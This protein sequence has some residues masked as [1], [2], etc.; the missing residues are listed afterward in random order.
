MPHIGQLTQLTINELLRP[1]KAD[2]SDAMEVDESDGSVKSRVLASL[3]IVADCLPV[4]TSLTL[5][6]FGLFA[7]VLF[8]L[9]IRAQKSKH[10]VRAMN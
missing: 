9:M 2:N 7:S 8:Q 5:K 10:N 6:A 4:L 1:A 3:L